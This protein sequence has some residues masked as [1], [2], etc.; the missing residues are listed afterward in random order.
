MS[1]PWFENWF[2]SPYYHILYKHRDE[3]E[4]R[5]FINNLLVFLKL[6]AGSKV[7]DQACG[8]GRHAIYLYE[9][10][11][12]VTGIDLSEESI[13]HTKQFENDRLSFFVHDMRKTFRINYFDLILNLFTSFGYFENLKENLAV[14]NA[15]KAG[16]KPK[17]KYVIDFM[18]VNKVKE[19]LISHE[20]KILE[21]IDFKISRHV[22]NKVI[23]KE[24]E[25][26][27]KGQDYHFYERVEALTLPDFEE[28]FK[29]AG[30]KILHLFGD[31][32]LKPFNQQSSDRLILVVEKQ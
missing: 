18:N 25:F 14:V 29:P 17:G 26:S 10:G 8:K 2:D 1:S 21:G 6:P 11:L 12:D 16:L 31:Y 15:A 19:M 5:V 20:E 4:A 22:E 3:D 27:D 32:S 23:V 7:L 13:K 30:L 9:H 28:L 24:I